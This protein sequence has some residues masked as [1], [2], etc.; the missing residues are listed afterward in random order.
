[1]I[2]RAFLDNFIFFFAQILFWAIIIR[3][4]L[5]WFNLSG[6]QP[7][8]RLLVEI[9]EPVLGPIRRVVPSLGMIDISP[10][11]AMILIQV[12]SGILQSSL[13]SLG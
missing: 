8:F 2:L 13:Q 12:I 10:L 3:A 6:G 5:S 4:L 11:I 7:V 1:M 9:T